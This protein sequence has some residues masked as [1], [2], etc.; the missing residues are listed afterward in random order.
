[1]H[2]CLVPVTPWLANIFESLRTPAKISGKA[3]AVDVPH[4]LL[5]LPFLLP[6]LL[7]EEVAEYNGENPFDPIR[8]PSD[9]CLE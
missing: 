9:A 7:Q 4:I 1:M 6:N 5:L 2:D 3:R 8:Y